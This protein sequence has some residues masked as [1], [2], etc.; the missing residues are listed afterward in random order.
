MKVLFVSRRGVF[1]T[2]GGEQTQIHATAAA[3]DGLGVDAEVVSDLPEH[4][5]R[6]DIVHFFGLDQDHIDK[7]RR[8]RGVPKA[9]TPVF[10]D[11]YQQFGQEWDRQG[12]SRV[13][14]RIT[15]WRRQL[16]RRPERRARRAGRDQFLKT[17]SAVPLDRRD[18]NWALFQEV[19]GAIDLFLPNSEME[20]DSVRRSFVFEMPPRGAVVHNAIDPQAVE[21]TSDF[22]ERRLG[23]GRFI[24]CS[25]G[26]DPRKNQF[27]LVRAL[28]GVGLPIVLAGQVRD[29]VYAQAVGALARAHGVAVRLLGHLDAP[30]LHSL[31]ARAAVHALPS[32]HETPG[33]SNLEAIAHGCPNVSTKIGGLEEYVGDYSLYCNPYSVSHI[34][35]Q[36]LRALE[37]ARNPEAAAFVRGRYTWENAARETKAAYDELLAGGGGAGTRFGGEAA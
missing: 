3:L 31:Y 20:M 5:G 23:D 13:A 15:K 8:A 11:R 27:N 22:A 25:A 2:E 29:E 34:R 7:I 37:M 6:Y 28:V 17:Q 36:V 19:V 35:R 26:V 30:D 18:Y 32:Y 14:R 9:L 12:R 1:S 24:L 4:Y 21:R 33:I 16:R 10:W